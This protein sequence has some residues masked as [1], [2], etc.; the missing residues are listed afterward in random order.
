MVPVSC[1]LS[2]PATP[3]SIAIAAPVVAGRAT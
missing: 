1:M 3:N 2:M